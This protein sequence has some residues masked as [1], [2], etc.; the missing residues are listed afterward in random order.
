MRR[1]PLIKIAR[2]P[3]RNAPQRARQL[4]LPEIF[5]PVVERTPFQKNALRFRKSRKQRRR[6]PPGI[7]LRAR[8]GEALFRQ[9]HR[10]FHQLSPRLSPV[11]LVRQFE[12]AHRSRHSHRPPAH[13]AVVR[14]IPLRIQVHIAAG[15]PW[16]FLAEINERSAPAGH[17]DEHESSAAEVSRVRMRHRQR[18]PHRHGRVHRISPGAQNRNANVRRQIF[19]RH[20]HRLAPVNRIAPLHRRND[21]RQNQQHRQ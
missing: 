2:P 8:N 16:R 12:S 10:G 18:K 7:H 3:T 5:L 13:H 1:L 21:E 6:A 15:L 17:A 4:R 19:L 14:R 20:H 9:R 11:L